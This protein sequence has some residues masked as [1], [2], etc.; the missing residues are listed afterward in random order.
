MN[1]DVAAVLAAAESLAWWTHANLRGTRYRARQAAF[2]RLREDLARLRSR[3][4]AYE[5]R[6]AIRCARD[7]AAC[8]DSN[9]W[10][11]PYYRRREA[12]ARLRGAL[13][14]IHLEA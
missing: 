14:A 8:S 13:G 9:R 1:P 3:P 5:L 6:A 7:L 12:F 4:R 10:G 11:P 2:A